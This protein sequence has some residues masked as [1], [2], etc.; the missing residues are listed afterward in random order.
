MLNVVWA[1]V[2]RVTTSGKILGPEERITTFEALRAIT[3]D[4]AWQNFEENRKGTL[5][6]GKLADMVVLSNDPLSIDPMA[7]KDIRVMQTIKE[8]ETIYLAKG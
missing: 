6:T 4:A 3:A 8:G 7:I 5:E 1:A 2:N